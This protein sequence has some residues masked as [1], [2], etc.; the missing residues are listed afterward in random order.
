MDVSS[1][2]SDVSSKPAKTEFMASIHRRP[3]SKYWH[4]FFRNS[5]GRLIDKSTRLK[6]RKQAQRVAD[7]LEMAAQRKKTAQHVRHLRTRKTAKS[8]RIPLSAP[9][10]PHPKTASLGQSECTTASPSL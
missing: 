1:A 8:L 4:A 10:H 3:A 5:E 9:L 7:T 2:S 6:D